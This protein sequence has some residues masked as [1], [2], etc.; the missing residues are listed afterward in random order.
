MIKQTW[1]NCESHDLFAEKKW[2]I[3]EI[4]YICLHFLP[5]HLPFNPLP[6]CATASLFT[7][8]IPLFYFL[9]SYSAAPSFPITLVYFLGPQYDPRCIALTLFSLGLRLCGVGVYMCAHSREREN[10]SDHISVFVRY[11]YSLKKCLDSEFGFMDFLKMGTSLDV[12]RCNSV[13]IYSYLPMWFLH[14][15]CL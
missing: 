13:G 10:N 8:S 4:A 6:L 12:S 9:S 3:L 11:L 5:L 7:T 2:S 14:E 1:W 15:K